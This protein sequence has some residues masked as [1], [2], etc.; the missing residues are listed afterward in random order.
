[1]V[2]RT[3]AGQYLS[4]TILPPYVEGPYLYCENDPVN[5]RDDTGLESFF[6]PVWQWLNEIFGGAFDKV[7]QLAE[8]L[9]ANN[10]QGCGSL[11]GENPLQEYYAMKEGVQGEVSNGIAVNALGGAVVSWFSVNPTTEVRM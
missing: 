9:S 7:D 11:V 10:G 1:M 8:A 2:Q 5:R 3:G 4:R 6:D